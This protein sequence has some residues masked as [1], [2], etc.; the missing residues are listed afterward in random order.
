M[1]AGDNNIQDKVA[2]FVLNRHN[3]LYNDIYDIFI[4]STPSYTFDLIESTAGEK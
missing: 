3:M 4:L 2:E 1:R